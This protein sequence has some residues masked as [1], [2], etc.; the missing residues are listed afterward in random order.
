MCARSLPLAT[1]AALAAAIGSESGLVEVP[2]NGIPAG[3]E[4]ITPEMLPLVQ[5]TSEQIE[6]I[7]GDGAWRRGQCCGHLSAGAVAGRD[8]FHHLLASEGD[9]YLVRYD[10]A[11]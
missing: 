6:G 7:V 10:A 11:L 1:L 3:C 8:S 9:P 4:L 5:L 2:P